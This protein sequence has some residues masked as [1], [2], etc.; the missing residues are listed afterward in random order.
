MIET[1]YSSFLPSTD[2]PGERRGRSDKRKSSVAKNRFE[3]SQIF[4]LRIIIEFG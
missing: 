1:I 2:T 4:V 3:L